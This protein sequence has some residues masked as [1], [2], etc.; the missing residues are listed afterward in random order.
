[1][2]DVGNV[3][4]SASVGRSAP[5]TCSEPDAAPVGVVSVDPSDSP[6]PEVHRFHYPKVLMLMSAVLPFLVA[7]LVGLILGT[8]VHRAI[9]AGQERR[10][11]ADHRSALS[12][13]DRREIRRSVREGT[14]VTD[15]VL[16]PPAVRFGEEVASSNRRARWLTDPPRWVYVAGR[17]FF[18]AFGVLA[19]VLGV[20]GDDAR[21]L[22]SGIVLLG[23]AVL[24]LPATVRWTTARQARTE[25]R[26][27]SSIDANR[28]LGVAS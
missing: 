23:L 14:P 5:T 22:V 16:A 4:V 12:A 19:V 18:P 25:A 24:Y 1:M 20:A 2:A 6:D 3:L 27:R 13:A 11:W 26:L 28:V 9:R 10:A 8:I 15:R 21:T 17:I 7:V